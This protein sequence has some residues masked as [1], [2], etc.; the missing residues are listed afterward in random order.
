MFGR[1]SQLTVRCQER[2]ADLFR[3]SIDTLQEFRSFEASTVTTDLDSVLSSINV[4]R[5]QPSTAVYI[6]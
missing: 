6:S 1:T 2:F 4:R 5:L 3:E